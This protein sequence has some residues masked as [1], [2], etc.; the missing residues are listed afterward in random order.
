[1][2][3]RMFVSIVKFVLQIIDEFFPTDSKC[4][5]EI[6]NLSSANQVIQRLKQKLNNVLCFEVKN[7]I[8]FLDH[9]I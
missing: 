5:L 6:F 1:M 9:D 7:K 2:S 8:D 3:N 4:T